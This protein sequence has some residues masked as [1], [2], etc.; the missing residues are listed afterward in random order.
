[1]TMMFDDAAQRR[2]AALRRYELLAELSEAAFAPLLALALELSG[3]DAVVVQLVDGRR[4]QRLREGGAGAVDDALLAQVLADGRLRRQ[5]NCAAAPLPLPE[6]VVVGALGVAGGDLTDGALARL[7]EL[8]AGELERWR[9]Q[10]ELRSRERALAQQLKLLQQVIEWVEAPV[11]IA[12]LAASQPRISYVNAAFCQLTGYAAEELIGQSFALL[13]GEKTDAAAIARLHAALAKAPAASSELVGYRKDGRE[14]YSRIQVALIQ[15]AHGD[16]THAVVT[17]LDLSD[18]RRQAFL[19]AYR[20]EVLGLIAAKSSLAD[21]M[22]RL[23]A[24]IEGYAPELMVAVHYRRVDYLALAYAPSLPEPLRQQLGH[25]PLRTMSGVQALIAQRT[26]L[27]IPDILAHRPW[28]RYH[29]AARESGVRSC[30]MMPIIDDGGQVC[31]AL[32][33]MSRQVRAPSSAELELLAEMAQLMAV[34]MSQRRLLAQLEH[35]A[36]FD[37]TTGLGNR[38]YLRERLAQRLEAAPLQPLAV[39]VIDID[40]LRQVND[41]YGYGVGDTLLHNIATR[42]KSLIAPRGVVARLYGDEFG[43]V[44]EVGKPHELKRALVDIEQALS[45]PFSINRHEIDIDISMGVSLYPEHGQTPDALLAFADSALSASK[46]SGGRRY[47]YYHPAIQQQLSAQL[48]LSRELKQALAGSGLTLYLQP[49]FSAEGQRLLAAEA[50][51]RWQHPS[52]G[53]LPP[54]EFLPV[55]EKAGLMAQLDRWVLEHACQQLIAWQ[56]QQLPY[57][58]SCNLSAASFNDADAFEQL[59]ALLVR[60]KVPL[61]QLELEITEA[62][63]LDQPEQAAGQLERLKRAC[64]GLRVAIDDFGTG[65]SS[66]AYLRYLPVDT[67]KI[68]RLFVRDLDSPQDATRTTARAIVSTVVLLGHQLGLSV[69]AEGVETPAQLAALVEL[70]CDELQGYAIAKP[71]PLVEFMALA[72]R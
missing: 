44:I 39:I 65:Y 19:A 25:L 60:L 23:A 14:F 40:N 34:A 15:D 26:P 50:L 13:Q 72:S 8:A 17:P 49:R 41:S 59:I 69:V 3:A 16:V 21:I 66:L 36:L 37:T 70:G 45:R 29:R 53:L 71:L 6:G 7:A 38:R 48:A 68:D 24:L 47:Q 56:R 61:S 64:P 46:A 12:E 11:A 52:R 22:A 63:L 31:G 18:H 35:Q 1:M 27:V 42:L 20:R 28:R 32:S 54:G 2:L 9:Q 5:G 67:L 10:L 30:W 55:A 4:W 33:L 58:L 43:V 57:R 62:M 51:V